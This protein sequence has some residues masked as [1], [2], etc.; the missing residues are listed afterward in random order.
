MKT[1][2]MNKSLFHCQEYFLQCGVENKQLKDENEKIRK[3]MRINNF[4]KITE[5]K[6]KIGEFKYIDIKNLVN[7]IENNTISE[8][9]AK[10]FV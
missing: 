7:N 8:I 10:K 6:N 3:E 4:K 5:L 2:V 9:D 1:F